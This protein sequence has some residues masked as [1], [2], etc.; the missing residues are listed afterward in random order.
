MS[1]YETTPQTTAV[2]KRGW[3]IVEDGNVGVHR[4][5]DLAA[6]A[7]AIHHPPDVKTVEGLA[8]A[9]LGCEVKRQ[10][11]GTRVVGERFKTVLGLSASD[12]VSAGI[13]QMP[14]GGTAY[15]AAGAGHEDGPA[16]EIRHGL[17]F[18]FSALRVVQRAGRA[19]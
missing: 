4:R 2:T 14:H 16:V 11:A 19:C 10:D 17:A 7:T 5:G 3:R 6:V 9:V 18:S 1:R 12:H 15:P 8:D 13:D